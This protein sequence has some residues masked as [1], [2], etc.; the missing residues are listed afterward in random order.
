MSLEL[1]GT[2]GLKGVA[3]SV[4]APSIVGD[5]TNTGIS[6][7]AADTIKF[8][9]NGVERLSIT[10]SGLSGDGSG[11]TGVGGGITVAQT[12]RRTTT[13]A[14]N[15]GTTYFGDSNWEKSDN[16]LQGGFGSFADPSN[17][18]F[19]FPTP[20]YYY[21]EFQSY[22]E[23][24][25]YSRS[26]Q[27]QI[28]ATNDN[29]N[30]SIISAVNFGNDYDVSSYAYQSGSIRTIIDVTDL[31]NQKVKF[32]AFSISTVSWDGSSSQD[33]TAATFIRLGDT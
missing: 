6:F 22:Y 8:S 32:G 4:S 2:T 10:N 18:V 15:N 7:P 12:F 11:L 1:S 24:S 20:G 14:T 5:D 30:Y 21:V 27:I 25:G 28:L 29:N 31:T 3:G 13:T 19:S 33:R 26:N 23:D 9:T 16:T 17:G